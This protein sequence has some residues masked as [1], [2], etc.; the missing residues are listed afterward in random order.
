MFCKNAL[1]P[2]N[3]GAH[4]LTETTHKLRTEEYKKLLTHKHLPVQTV[5]GRGSYISSAPSPVDSPRE[6]LPTTGVIAKGLRAPF[7]ST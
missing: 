5:R 3:M 6:P 4:Q 7:S 2:N 1:E